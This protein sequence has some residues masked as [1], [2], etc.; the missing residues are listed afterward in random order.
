MPMTLAH[1]AAVLPLRRYGMPMAALVIGSMIPDV[2]VFLGWTRAYRVSHSALGVVSVD[3]VGALVLL[4]GWNAFGRDALVDLAPDRVRAR[5]AARHRLSRRQWQWAPAAAVLGSVTHLV[6]DSFTH[7][8]RW[9]VLHLAVLRADLGPLPA[10]RWAQYT[11][12]AIGLGVVLWAVAADLRSRP[13]TQRQRER[14]LPAALLPLVLGATAAYG[15][16]AGLADLREGLHAVAFTG[17]VQGVVAVGAG[18]G[19]TCLAWL[20]ATR[21]RAERARP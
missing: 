19:A 8:G 18:T 3:L 16:V 12:G 2:P 20:L 6:W 10:F 4:W 11:S 5:L 7:P 1:P 14:V 9:G 13:P 21:L 17:V 15:L